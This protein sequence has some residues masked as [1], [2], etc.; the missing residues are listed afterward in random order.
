MDIYTGRKTLQT[1]D[2]PAEVRSWGF[3]EK[4]IP[5][6]ADSWEKDTRQ[7][8]GRYRA[9]ADAPWVEIYRRS[10]GREIFGVVRFLANGKLI[11]LTNK[12]RDNTV[13]S[14]FDPVTKTFGAVIAAAADGYDMGF[15]DI[16][17]VP[18]YGNPS[19]GLIFDPEET[20]KILGFDYQGA[21]SVRTWIDERYAAMQKA[22]DAALPDR[23]NRFAPFK[24]GVR[25]LVTSRS[26]RHPASFFWFDP[27][28]QTLETLAINSPWIQET[29][30]ARMEPIE[31]TARDGLRIRG[32]LTMP[33]GKEPKNL[34]LILHPHGGPW[35]RDTWGY[36]PEIQFLAALGYAVLQMDFRIS[37]GY[38]NKHFQAGWKTIGNEMQNDKMDGLKWV[39]DKGIVDPKR[40]C[41]YGGSYG[42]YAALRAITRDADAFRCGV[43]TVGVSDWDIIMRGLWRSGRETQ[44]PDEISEW[45]GSLDNSDDRRR[46]EKISVLSSAAIQNVKV[47]LLSAYGFNDPR[48]PIEHLKVLERAMNSGG[49]AHDTIVYPNE[50]HGWARQENTIDWYKRLGKFVVK[51]NPPN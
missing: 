8:V 5:R 4:L 13:V 17:G 49:K 38:G 37:T 14:E 3:D 11:V 46:F 18:N 36:N 35:A 24:K 39:V 40:V 51:H 20:E 41:V 19:G 45:I 6:F 28:K 32:Y 10:P 33:L 27:E 2:R 22:I 25:P 26:D 16:G 43:N 30:M 50:G 31:Y 34:P 23:S 21:K 9:S 48:V 7:F 12:D 15:E 1:L 29:E 42:G 47:P 44:G